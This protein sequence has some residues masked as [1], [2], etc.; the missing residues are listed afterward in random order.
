MLICIQTKNEPL[1]ACD[2]LIVKETAQLQI[3]ATDLKAM[4]QTQPDIRLVKEKENMLL[5]CGIL[6][7]QILKE[8]DKDAVGGPVQI[9]CS[10]K[11]I[12]DAVC[13]LEYPLSD[14]TEAKCIPAKADAKP[15]QPR[16]KSQGKTAGTRSSATRRSN[17]AAPKPDSKPSDEPLPGTPPMPDTDAVN[18]DKPNPGEPTQDAAQPDPNDD[19]VGPT[20]GNEVDLSGSQL[21]PK[22]PKPGE[23]PAAKIMNMLR[24]AGI[25]SGQLPGVLDAIRESADPD[26]TLPLQ[27]KM[28]LTKDGAT[29]AMP[30]EET[31]K[32]VAPLFHDIKSLMEEAQRS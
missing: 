28:K 15:S 22:K 11:P 2:I 7:A 16:P 21:E 31:A 10:D 14:K 23:A 17:A 27:I 26:M 24:D 3:P 25:P 32:R 8:L 13:S 9:A 12:L 30:F 19:P 4:L 5:K 6:I 18:D 20:V 1:R 29:D